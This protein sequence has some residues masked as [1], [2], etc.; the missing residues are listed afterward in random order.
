LTNNQQGHDDDGDGNGGG[1]SLVRLVDGHHLTTDSR[2][3]W[4]SSFNEQITLQIHLDSVCELGGIKIWNYNEDPYIGVKRM[5]IHVGELLVSPPDGFLLRRGPGNDHYDYGQVL[6]FILHP[7]DDQTLENDVSNSLPTGFVYQIQLLSTWSDPYYI[8]LTGLQMTD[9]NHHIIP[10]TPNNIAAYPNSVNVLD[11][12]TDDVRT[13]DKLI[14]GIIDSQEYNHMWLSPVLPSIYNTVYVIFDKLQ[15]LSS[16]TLWNYGKTP[17]RG[18]REFSVLV[19]GILI[20]TGVLPQASLPTSGILPTVSPPIKSH[21]INLICASLNDNEQ[22]H[23]QH[24]RDSLIITEA[25]ANGT[26]GSTNSPIGLR[27]STSVTV[28][29]TRLKKR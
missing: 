24:Q 20:Y 18:V 16:I 27:P 17:S 10:L 3:M 6:D 14:D 28:N 2:H 21:T 22:L 19:D 23:V 9:A 8:G 29:K 5:K 4:T 1:S 11:G 7:L 25:P 12:I 26:T 13:P 15:S